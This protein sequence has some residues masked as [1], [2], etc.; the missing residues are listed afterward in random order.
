MSM[1]SAFSNARVDQALQ[2]SPI[3]ALRRLSVEETEDAIIVS[4]SVAT[5]YEKQLAQETIMPL[6]GSRELQNRVTVRS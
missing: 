6:R 2:Q 5:Y 4:G 3:P 1:S